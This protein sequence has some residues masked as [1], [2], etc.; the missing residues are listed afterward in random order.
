MDRLVLCSSETPI[1]RIWGSNEPQCSAG[2]SRKS[3]QLVGQSAICDR[4]LSKC[5]CFHFS[6]S[7][8]KKRANAKEKKKNEGRNNSALLHME[9]FSFPPFRSKTKRRERK[10]ERKKE[11]QPSSCAESKLWLH[12]S[13]ATQASKQMARPKVSQFQSVKIRPTMLLN[14]IKFV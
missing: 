1:D 8:T 11:K 9:N 14:Y 12:G 4:F 10:R 7:I 6:D 2:P 5:H 13:C 3:S